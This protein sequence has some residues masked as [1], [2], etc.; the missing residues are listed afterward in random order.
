MS[1]YVT[2]KSLNIGHN[3]QQSFIIPRIQKMLI[4]VNIKKYVSFMDNLCGIIISFTAINRL[5]LTN[6]RKMLTKSCYDDYASIVKSCNFFKLMT[7]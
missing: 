3:F 2:L 5:G 4:Y 7:R 6:I 1:V